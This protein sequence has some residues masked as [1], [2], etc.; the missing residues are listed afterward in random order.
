MSCQGLEGVEREDGVTLNFKH[1]VSLSAFK[2][3]YR[4]LSAFLIMNLLVHLLYTELI[5]ADKRAIITF[6]NHLP[7][8]VPSAGRSRV[9]L[10]SQQFAVGQ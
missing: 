3:F 1:Q 10:A 6:R 5:M 7:Q 4:G 8:E 2:Q 9:L